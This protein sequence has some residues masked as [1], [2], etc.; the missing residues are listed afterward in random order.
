[1]KALQITEPHHSEI[2]KIPQPS[3]APG[4]VLLQ[5]RKIGFCGSDLATFQGHN[6]LVNYPRIPGHEISATISAVTS[7]VPE[8]LVS[9]MKVTVVPYTNCG[10]C[11]SCRRGRFHACR[12]NQTLGVQRDGALTEFLAVPWQKVIVAPGLSDVQLAL[13]E[14]LT[15]GFH[16]VDRGRVEAE[17]AVLVFGCGMIG[18]G[19][20]AGALYR[21]SRVIAVDIDDAKL[22]IARR[23]G[24]AHTINSK[25]GDLHQQLQALT[26]GHG[27]DV[28]VEAVGSPLTYRTAVEVVAF[29]GRVVYIGY[30]K[31]EVS[32]ATKLFVQKELDILGSRNATAADFERVTRYLAESR[33][34][35]SDVVSRTVSPEQAGE[36]LSAW[37]S[38][39]GAYTKILVE[40]DVN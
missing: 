5:I 20:I 24:A 38:N 8:M 31:E 28:V 22:S 29:A 11:A 26:S 25:S 17:D 27:P 15:V 6:P 4:E 2:V 19:A 9:G 18:L 32:F 40:L 13:V 35:V 14:P 39:P 7:G 30:S 33:F 34:P 36:A 16:A 12:F 3:P 21:K 23:I 10:A 1:M 37:S